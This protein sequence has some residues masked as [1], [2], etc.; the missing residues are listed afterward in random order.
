MP[1]TNFLFRLSKGAS[2]AYDDVFGRLVLQLDGDGGYALTPAVKFQETDFTIE[3]WFKSTANGKR[4]VLFADWSKPWQFLIAITASGE[5][6]V[7]LRR[8][9]NSAGSDPNQDLLIAVGG[10]VKRDAWQHLVVTYANKPGACA[11]YLN[12]DKVASV[13]TKWT[14][15]DLQENSHSTYEVGYKKDGNNAFFKGQIALLSINQQTFKLG[16]T[17]KNIL[18]LFFV[19]SM[20]F[21]VSYFHTS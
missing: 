15:H 20:I 12:N 4:Q 2:F 21:T 1:F 3:M 17:G 10:S 14:N 18:L 9:I 19:E 6:Q 7:T 5:I 8:N 13:T 11:V 16:H